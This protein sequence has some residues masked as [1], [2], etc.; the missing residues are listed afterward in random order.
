[1]K[2]KGIL[3]L[4]LVIAAGM[5]GIGG[6]MVAAGSGAAG[7]ATVTIV[8]IDFN[9]GDNTATSVG[10]IS[11]CQEVAPGATYTA[12]VIVQNV[13]GDTDPTTPDGMVA[14]Q[15]TFNSVPGNTITART[16]TGGFIDQGAGIGVPGGAAID[17]EGSSTLPDA[18]GSDTPLAVNDPSIGVSGA[19]GSGFL[20]RLTATAPTVTRATTVPLTLTAVTLVD[21]SAN[22][23]PV[24]MI[25]GATL[26]IAPDTTTNCATLPATPSPSP[27]PTPSPTPK[28]TG[29]DA[30]SAGFDHTCALKDGR[31]WCWGSNSAG[32]LG[33]GT[34]MD[35]G[36]PVAVSGLGSGVS[37][38]SAGGAHTC[39]LKDGGVRCWGWNAYGQVG[40]GTTTESDVPLE[41]SGLGSGVSAISAGGYHT[42]A[43]K[44]GGVKCWGLN[45][46]GELGN[47]TTTNSSVPVGVSGLGSGISSIS[48]GGYHTCALKDGG[49]KCWGW[50]SNGQ[51]GNGTTTDSSVP[52]AVVFTSSVG[53]IGEAIDRATLPSRTAATSGHDRMAYELAGVVGLVAVVAGAGALWRRRRSGDGLPRH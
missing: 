52:V 12:D 15:F 36:V 16:A 41:V 13:P 45:F 18:T 34:T 27:T 43:L 23:I 25:N 1:M 5:L 39:A 33:N 38:I 49:V 30:I 42:C 48:G 19:S 40:D 46:Y 21:A 37:A 6:L 2:N 47:G 35:S 29:T 17:N 28:P 3:A 9:T 8:T 10:A 11:T 53:G 31:A 24:A 22:E 50:N 44:D 32:E 14:G 4:T 26:I 51:L 20:V 7:P